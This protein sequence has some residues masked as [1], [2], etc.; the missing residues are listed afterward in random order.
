MYIN[1]FFKQ[2]NASGSFV[3]PT[4]TTESTVIR[5]ILDIINY[6][7]SEET[8]ND[9]CRNLIVYFSLHNLSTWL[10]NNR[11]ILIRA[12]TTAVTISLTTL[13]EIFCFI[14]I[15]VTIVVLHMARN[16]R[17]D[18]FIEMFLGLVVSDTFRK[19]EAKSRFG[20]CHKRRDNGMCASQVN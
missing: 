16:H 20:W 17:C 2:T 4:A 13:H 11:N 5:K 10:E 1:V 6:R 3:C 18:V 7:D 15:S 12:S 8:K 19:R 14:Q 9:F